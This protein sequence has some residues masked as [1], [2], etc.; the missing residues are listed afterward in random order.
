MR[1]KLLR[2]ISLSC[3]MT[4]VLF[5]RRANRH[6]PLL[7]RARYSRP[8]DCRPPLCQH[9]EQC[10]CLSSRREPMA[11]PRCHMTTHGSEL[12]AAADLANLADWRLPNLPF[13]PNDRLVLHPADFRRKPHLSE[14]L[15]TPNARMPPQPHPYRIG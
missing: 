15:W 10:N 7:W 5:L 9:P 14:V 8:T 11:S 4:A 13:L 3:W 2:V 6:R 12:S 1:L